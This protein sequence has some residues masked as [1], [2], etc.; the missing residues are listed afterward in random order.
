MENLKKCFSILQKISKI[1]EN[2]K[3]SCFPS[4]MH[5]FQYNLY[6]GAE[7]LGPGGFVI[8][9]VSNFSA[10]HLVV[11]RILARGSLVAHERRVFHDVHHPVVTCLNFI[12]HYQ[13]NLCQK[14]PW[15]VENFRNI[16]IH[17]WKFDF[18]KTIVFPCYFSKF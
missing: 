3:C 16:L 5:I 7:I 1:L 9:S 18:Q 12:V 17:T 8:Y 13:Q 2:K 15:Q 14:V 6:L 11:W 4:Y 10:F